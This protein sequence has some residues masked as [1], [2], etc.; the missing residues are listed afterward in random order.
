V[1]GRP[2]PPRGGAGGRAHE[3]RSDAHARG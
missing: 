3:L 2:S 1:R